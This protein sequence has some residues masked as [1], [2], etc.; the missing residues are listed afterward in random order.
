MPSSAGVGELIAIAHLRLIP[1]VAGSFA[2]LHDHAGARVE[3][4]GG[5][6]LPLSPRHF[7]RRFGRHQP[8][9]TVLEQ[10]A[11]IYQV[12]YINR[13]FERKAATLRTKLVLLRFL[14]LPDCGQN[15]T[16]VSDKQYSLSDI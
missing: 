1:G 5:Q 8:R 3:M 12:V 11:N 4:C 13:G 16:A 2:A 6:E 9:R 14:S 15:Q 7:G 10:V